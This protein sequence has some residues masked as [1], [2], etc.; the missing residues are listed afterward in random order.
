VFH[1]TGKRIINWERRKYTKEQ[2][3]EAWSSSY[4][5]AEV[6]R[7]LDANKSG[8]GYYTLK[9][10]AESL[11]LNQD[12]M[13]STRLERTSHTVRIRRPLKDILVEHSAYKGTSHLK[14]RL[15]KE[16]VLEKRC[17][18]CGISE[19]L[20]APAPLALDHI[21]GVRDDNRIENLRIL[22]FNC[23]GNTETYGSR[24]IAYQKNGSDVLPIKTCSAC[25]TLLCFVNKTGLCRPC[26]NK[27]RP[28]QTVIDWP[29]TDVLLEMVK[30]S[31]YVRVA[32]S[33]GVSDNAIRKR[34]KNHPI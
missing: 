1:T 18:I 3:V 29:T 34:I 5:L 28:R 19:W 15:Y 22:C 26:G 17:A 21:N 12:H 6:G 24:N 23:H 20:G 9:D 33:L 10:T 2:F 27:T 8:N 30:E 4:C 25:S 32:K 7:K 31:N 11:G 13:P 16:G 14:E